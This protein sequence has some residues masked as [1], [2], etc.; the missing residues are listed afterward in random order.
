[1]LCSGS[2]V[3][4]TLSLPPFLAC[5]R[6]GSTAVRPGMRPHLAKTFPPA[7]THDSVNKNSDELGSLFTVTVT[8]SSGERTTD[9]WLS[10][11]LQPLKR[12]F[13][14]KPENVPPTSGRIELA[15]RSVRTFDANNWKAGKVTSFSGE[16]QNTIYRGVMSNGSVRDVLPKTQQ[17]T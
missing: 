1:M 13:N 16:S 3:Y 17:S 12:P 8:E 4:T 7:R 9:Y 14:Q 11:H 5:L 10:L 2:S 6:G 15:S